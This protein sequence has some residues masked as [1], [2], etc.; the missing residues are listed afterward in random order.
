MH[1]N[2]TKLGASA[3]GLAALMVLAGCAGGGDSNTGGDASPAPGGE[4]AKVTHITVSV[5]QN[6]DIN[7]LM[8]SVGRSEGFFEDNGVIVDEVI[9]AEGGG[10]TLQNVIAGKLPFGQVA[11]S[12][13]VKAFN[14]GLPIRIIAGATQSP[15]EIGWGVAADS[16]FKTIKDLENATWGFT[17]PGSVTEAMSYLVPLHAGLD[18]DKVKRAST[19]GVGAGIALLQAGDVD[20]T[21]TP[22][23]VELEQAKDLRVVV[24]S[25]EFVPVYGNTMIVSSRDYAAKNPEVA[26]G[27]LQGSLE[28]V[29]WI[30][31][32][33]EKA[34]DMYAKSV[35]VDTAAALEVIKAYIEED[36]WG[37]AFNP[38]ALESVAEGLKYTDGLETVDWKGLLTDEFLPEGKKGQIPG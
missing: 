7:G 26:R 4:G 38:E 21:F 1:L 37:L 24:H 30:K 10:T 23:L 22:P 16:E 12:A 36:L 6:Q 3:L 18:M 28:A 8:W 31:A 33:P 17:G 20:V 11:T 35:E 13:L 5:A 29:E 25:S 9:P 32:N 15:Y 14:E 34:A 27:L 19:G 2:R